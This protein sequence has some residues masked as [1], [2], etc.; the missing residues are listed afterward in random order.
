M[1]YIL[2]CISLVLLLVSCRPENIVQG[3][4]IEL[5]KPGQTLLIEKDSAFAAR[6]PQTLYCGDIFIA[7]DSVMLLYDMAASRNSGCFYKAYSLDDYSYLG[8]LLR[9]GRSSGEV[10]SPAISG[11]CLSAEDGK[12]TCYFWDMML[13]RSYSFNLHDSIDDELNI[14]EKISELPTNTIDAFPYKDSL[15]FVVNVGNDNILFHIINNNSERLKT[16]R[17]YPEDISAERYLPIF[18]NS[19]SV[20]SERNMAALVMLSIPQ[21]NFLNLEDGTVHSVAVDRKYKEWRNI[22]TAAT[23]IPSYMKTTQYYNDA[24][25]TP[26]YIMALY[27]GRKREDII[28]GKPGPSPRIH[29]FDW[30]GKFLYDLQISEHISRIAFDSKRRF[31]YGLDT[32]EGSIYR[33]DL[34]DILR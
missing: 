34:S 8:E 23:D 27:V 22:L 9:E 3:A 11:T 2:N 7:N 21:I 20:S 6:F 24:E 1:K 12:T 26:D 13:F 18:S 30:E 14:I 31:M 17:L 15:Q 25:S 29:I 33:Y 32:D 28:N 19:I 4:F 10:I 16:F 5:V